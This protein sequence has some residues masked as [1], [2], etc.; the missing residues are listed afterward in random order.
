[1]ILILFFSLAGAMTGCASGPRLRSTATAPVDDDI[2]GRCEMVVANRPEGSVPCDGIS[3]FL[4]SPRKGEERRATI[5]GFNFRF[6]N[7]NQRSYV[8]SAASAGYDVETNVK[9]E[10]T[11]GQT[12]KIRVRANPRP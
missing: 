12:I 6:S 10:L 1:M 4:R 9:S 8:L 5:D 7:L 2:T 3:L 11:P